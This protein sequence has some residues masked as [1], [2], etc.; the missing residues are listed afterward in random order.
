V[1]AR[2]PLRRSLS[3][4]VSLGLVAACYAAV[5]LVVVG[6]DLALEW[7]EAVYASQ[8]ARE[9]T[10]ILFHPSRGWGPALLAAPV[11]AVT[12]AEPTLRLYLTAV[13]SLALFLAF[14]VWLAVRPGH[15]IPV[16]AVFFAACWPTT[17][18]GGQLMPNLYTALIAVA[19]TGLVLRPGLT[20]AVPSRRSLA[21]TAALG[22][23]LV[24]F[25]PSDAL[26]ITTSLAASAVAVLPWLDGVA[27]AGGT[28]VA[29]P[30]SHRTGRH[31]RSGRSSWVRSAGPSVV[32]RAVGWSA[33]RRWC[34]GPHRRG[35]LCVL[36]ALVAGSGLGWAQWV[37]EA[38]LGYGGVARRMAESTENFGPAR[39]LLG[40]HLRALDGPL[41]C[42]AGAGCGPI[43]V[44]GLVW[45]LAC[46]LL[47]ALGLALAWHG[48][49]R[50]IVMAWR[51]GGRRISVTSHGRGRWVAVAVP[52]VV[53][54]AAGGA[55]LY[56]PGLTAARYL[57]PALALLAVP[58]AEA[59]A[60]LAA[61]ARAGLRRRDRWGAVGAS[62]VTALGALAVAGHL[63]LHVSYLA[64]NVRVVKPIRAA[65]RAVAGK[66]A[67][68]GVRRPCLVYGWSAPQIAY[69][70]GC[71]AVGTAGNR[72]LPATLPDVVREQAPEHGDHTIV[73]VFRD[74]A[75][76]SAPYLADWPEHRLTGGWYARVRTP[77]AR[78]RS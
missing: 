52:F 40:A 3:P 15:T 53:G 55:Y 69:R 30:P 33:W 63:G 4:Q 68:L 34:A 38:W 22:L 42:G 44:G 67:T 65:E 58:L 10:P 25:R 61:A 54:A 64:E 73:A 28:T 18:Y 56:F 31:R 43:P 32:R 1:T 71:K 17:Y 76:A 14:R 5:Q 62:A 57:L 2:R 9:G 51:G 27:R 7:D 78:T 29:P 26:V 70:L 12:D 24:L 20:G 39:L 75:D 45:V 60:V 49:A 74:Q 8:T 23:L 13:S 19:L 59:A 35:T 11:V 47:G 41:L 21:G 50:R 36:A 48:R 16:A 72:P 46:A 66:I 6:T 77:D 37:V